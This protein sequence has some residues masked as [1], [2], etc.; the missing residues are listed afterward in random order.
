MKHTY[1]IE[2]FFLDKWIRL[3]TET[4]DFCSGYMSHAQYYAP[5]NAMRIMRGD[6][7]VVA[8]H[9]ARDDV[10][11]GMIASWPS[12]EQYESAAA[13]ANAQALRIRKQSAKHEER[14]IARTPTL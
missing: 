7:K 12:P 6:G 14:R 11:I 4:S 2:T 10:N 13:A 5:R 1:S 9:D 8:E 3:F